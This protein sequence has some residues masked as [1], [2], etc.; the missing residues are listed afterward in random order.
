MS[1]RSDILG[2]LREEYAARFV[3]SGRMRAWWWYAGQAAV[4]G[5]PFVTHRITQTLLL[6]LATD[7]RDGWR[8]VRRRPA[9]SVLVVASLGLGLGLATSVFTVVNGLLYAPLPYTA[10]GRLV[11][12]DEVHPTE[13]CQG[14]SV[15]APVQGLPLWRTARTLQATEAI[16]SRT[17]V[18]RIDDVPVRV[19]VAAISPGVIHLLGLR[20]A[21]G[22]LAMAETDAAVSDAAVF[23]GFGFWQSQFGGSTSVVG[24]VI[25][26]DGQPRTIA[27]VLA[28]D[29]PL[30]IRADVVER[31]T[32]VGAAD[33]EARRVTAIARLAPDATN[34]QATTELALLHR[35]IDNGQ[36]VADGWHVRV[37][38]LRTALM[39]DLDDPSASWLA[40]GGALLVLVAAGLNVCS[41]L[42]AQLAG[43]LE[44]LGVRR[45]LGAD[46]RRLVRLVMAEV[47]WLTLAGAALALVLAVVSKHALVVA[48]GGVLPPWVAFPIDRHVLSTVLAL[49]VVVTIVVGLGPAVASC[50]ALE[51]GLSA[52]LRSVRSSRR[53]RRLRLLVA[54][55]VAL[56]VILM[57]GTA[58]VLRSTRTIRDF[59]TLGHR[60]SGITTIATVQFGN[61]RV[62]SASW[63]G[64]MPRMLEGLQ[65]SADVSLA[66]VERAVFLG[67]WG[68]PGTPSAIRLDGATEHVPDTIAPRHSLA[69]GPDWFRLM[70]VP[71]LRGRPIDARD[72]HGAPGAVV[73]S[74]SVASSFWPD[75]D[76]L[77]QVIHIDGWPTPLSVVGVAAD[78]AANPLSE[79]RRILPRIY[80]SFVQAPGASSATWLVDGRDARIRAD[81][82]T[83]RIHQLDADA[84]V[85]KVSTVEAGLREWTASA[86][87]IAWVLGTAGV[88]AL[89]LVALGIHGT[90]SFQVASTRREL[91]VRRALG[92]RPATLVT[93]TL[94]A[95][96]VAVA[97]AVLVGASTAWALGRLVETRGLGSTSPISLTAAGGVIVAGALLA[98]IISLRRALAVTP[99][100]ALREE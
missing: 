43:R 82:W 60:V 85:T 72:R 12:I 42:I 6:G 39:D 19:D 93:G 40:L 54:V 77:G 34:E 3:R 14:C 63:Q 83:Q 67:S 81:E 75:A 65:A 61:D 21:A 5:V 13:V 74:Q 57:A 78:V 4:L 56:G 8:G 22:H 30:P 23:V 89:G 38:N 96:W 46:R 70:D 15:G 58:D 53:H 44:E 92:A 73:V 31:L 24:R 71:I 28:Q 33:N 64:R 1:S 50:R 99:L 79:S 48:L 18:A 11:E 37:R 32:L 10:P 17:T 51:Q 98:S 45:A 76:A 16:D 68:G 49:G 94:R 86:V 97:A 95:L 26:L 27:G 47:M 55:Q 41:V 7:A 100:S 36:R 90:L 35:S 2:D 20:P 84:I 59:S 69:V 87:G 62:D 9:L 88:V 25:A 52:R 80:A 66:T 29:T 91:G